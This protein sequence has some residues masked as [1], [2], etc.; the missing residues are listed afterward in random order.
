M[1]C[2]F[3]DFII[4][5]ASTARKRSWKGWCTAGGPLSFKQIAWK[6]HEK[7]YCRVF[8][9]MVL[10]LLKH[11]RQDFH[12][13]VRGACV[14][15]TFTSATVPELWRFSWPHA[16]RHEKGEEEMIEQW[17]KTTTVAIS[18]SVLWVQMS[19]NC[20]ESV[21]YA[22]SVIH[23]TCSSLVF[24]FP[25]GSIVPSLLMLAVKRQSN[26]FTTITVRPEHQTLSALGPCFRARPTSAQKIEFSAKDFLVISWYQLVYVRNH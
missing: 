17:R 23:C 19:W 2:H 11:G 9:V 20:T 18:T 4:I 7:W 6:M 21:C 1:Q 22:P 10:T 25:A 12:W 13:L 8:S 15:T 5:K 24:G 3:V 26:H 16:D 14:N